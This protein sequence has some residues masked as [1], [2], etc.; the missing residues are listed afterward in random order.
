MG[1]TRVA[2]TAESLISPEEITTQC[3][4]RSTEPWGN[5]EGLSRSQS[6]TF[7]KSHTAGWVKRRGN[8]SINHLQLTSLRSRQCSGCTGG[9]RQNFW[10][11]NSRLEVE[12]KRD[13]SSTSRR[14]CSQ[15][16]CG[17]AVCLLHPGVTQWADGDCSETPPQW[18]SQTWRQAPLPFRQFFVSQCLAVRPTAH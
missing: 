13:M 11:Q 8:S 5:R 10:N 17:E 9:T 3:T 15:C 14:P 7:Y 6:C 1:F 16:R 2:I 12:M 4:Q 18:K